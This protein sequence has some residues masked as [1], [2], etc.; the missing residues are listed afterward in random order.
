MIISQP[1]SENT[2][3]KRKLRSHT[4][5]QYSDLTYPKSPSSSPI[6]TLQENQL[7][8]N[9]I[10]D[11]F[12]NKH[13]H[14]N[15]GD[16]NMTSTAEFPNDRFALVIEAETGNLS[17]ID[18]TNSRNKRHQCQNQSMILNDFIIMENYDNNKMQCNNI[19]DSTFKS[20]EL[21]FKTN[22]VAFDPT[23]LNL[24]KDSCQEDTTKILSQI[25]LENDHISI[26]KNSDFDDINTSRNYLPINGIKQYLE[27]KN[28]ILKRRDLLMQP[29]EDLRLPKIFQDF[30]INKKN[31]L[32]KKNKEIRH[33]VPFVIIIFFIIF[34]FILQSPTRCFMEN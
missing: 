9:H 6:T 21:E 8:E 16:I 31:Y 10:S 30:L 28:Q 20:N 2:T 18:R 1:E 13:L 12:L 3:I 25:N 5:Q 23:Q 27:I 7:N 19:N 22:Q 33:L 15:Y 34:A 4:R 14:A 11:Q 17:T 32:I 26:N 24:D 29:K